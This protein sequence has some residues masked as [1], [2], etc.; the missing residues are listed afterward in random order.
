MSAREIAALV[1]ARDI[2][3]AEIVEHF[4]ARLKAVNTRLNVVTVELFD[5]A[6]KTAA[7][8]DG[9]L[10]RGEKL[11][12][13]AGLPVTI[14]ECFDLAGTASTFGLPSRRS[15]IESEDDPY[16]AAL[17]AAGAIP[18]A[19]TNVPQ[20]L[21]YTESDNPLYGRTNN[22]WNVERSCGGSSGG[23]AA[24]IAAG[25]SPLGLGND[26]GGSLRI[27]AAFCGIAS[28]RPTAGRTPDRCAHGLPIG[29]QAIVSPVGPMAKRV[30][31]L[32]M[33]LRIIER[34]RDPLLEPGPEL[35]DPASVELGR[36]GFATFTDDGE[37]PVAPAARRAVAEAAQMLI[38][39]GAKRVEWRKPALSQVN[40]LFFACLS[41]DHGS[42][43][44]R[45]LRGNRVDRRIRSLLLTGQM[46]P[47]L[48]GILRAALAAMGQQHSATLVRR[49]SSGSADAYWQ[50]VAAMVRFRRDFLQSLDTADGPIDFILCPAYAV[51]AQRHGASLMMPLPGAYAPLAPV[52]GLPA[53]IVPVT[54]V[55]PGEESDRSESR[56][57]VERVA[58]ESERASAG[59]PIAVQVIARPWHDHVAL[60]AMAA[61]EATAR[62]QRDYPARPPL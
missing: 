41:G 33:A 15:V 24:L 30:D 29:Q 13:L 57:Q 20:L 52:T 36:L 27:P 53:G 34:G 55:L 38:A 1:A 31:D 19:K 25:A 51:P 28:I 42:A 14:K 43:F 8:F 9:A 11:A 61:I 37:F 48:R 60:A 50:T 16:V 54:R 40:D 21:I 44:N 47:W 6:R 56:D 10:L 35:G 26:I 4:I 17:R 7:K 12:P 22:P 49:I 59:L 2:P 58:R 5:S 45:M 62:K 39:A 18:I 23:E 32:T 3:A 46:P